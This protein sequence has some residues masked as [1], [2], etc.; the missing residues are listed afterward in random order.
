[1]VHEF[2]ASHTR[3]HESTIDDDNQR[4]FYQVYRDNR[5]KSHTTERRPRV[6]VIKVSGKGAC[7]QNSTYRRRFRI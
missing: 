4:Q 2:L 6:G 3:D 7:V 1:M 5:D